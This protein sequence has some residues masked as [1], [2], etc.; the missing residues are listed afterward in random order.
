MEKVGG[1]IERGI[2]KAISGDGYS[3]LSYDRDGIETP[4]LRSV[5]GKSYSIGDRVYFFYFNDGTG[6][7]ICGL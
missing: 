5:D 7:I 2:I 3:I 4:P 1:N 6:K